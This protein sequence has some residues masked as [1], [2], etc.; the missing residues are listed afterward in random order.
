M[1]NEK[2]RESLLIILKVIA[3]IN[4]SSLLG[5]VKVVRAE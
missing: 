1:K 2:M 5:I 4:V 3:V